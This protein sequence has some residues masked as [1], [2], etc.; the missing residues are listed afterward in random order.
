MNFSNLIFPTDKRSR[1]ITAEN[2]TGEEGGGGRATEGTG[3]FPARN[4]GA[5]WKISPSVEIPPH[6]SFTLADIRGSGTITHIWLTI[7]PQ[8]SRKNMALFV[9]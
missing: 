2:F 4:L 3:A 1:S 5:G 7:L 8:I 6:S 9:V